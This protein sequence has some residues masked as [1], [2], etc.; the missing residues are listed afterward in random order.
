LQVG[1]QFFLALTFELEF[2]AKGT[3]GKGGLAK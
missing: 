1:T 3:R 2:T